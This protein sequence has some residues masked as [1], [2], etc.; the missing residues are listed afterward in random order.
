MNVFSYFAG[1]GVAAC[2]RLNRSIASELDQA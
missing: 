1:G 2:K